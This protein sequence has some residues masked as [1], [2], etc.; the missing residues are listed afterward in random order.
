MNYTVGDSVLLTWRG[1]E[2]IGKV[3]RITPA[4]RI[5]VDIGDTL[6]VEFDHDGVK[7]GNTRWILRK[8]TAQDVNRINRDMIQHL[9]AQ[10]VW[11]RVDLA[12]LTSIA[13]LLN[14]TVYKL[15]L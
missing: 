11:T 6:P 4:G 13:A 14:I 2:Q 7:R 10:T 15:E 12:T 3:L 9:V 8:L 1:S 5:I